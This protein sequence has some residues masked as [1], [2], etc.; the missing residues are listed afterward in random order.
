MSSLHVV[1]VALSFSLTLFTK[2]RIIFIIFRG[3]ISAISTLLAPLFRA[4]FALVK[5]NNRNE[6]KTKGAAM[7]ERGAGEATSTSTTAINAHS[8]TH[9]RT[10]QNC[11]QMSVLLRTREYAT[12]LA[13]KTLAKN[14]R[15]SVAH[16]IDATKTVRLRKVD[17]LRVCVSV[18]KQNHKTSRNKECVL[19]MRKVYVFF[20]SIVFF[21][22]S[23]P[24]IFASWLSL[25]VASSPFRPRSLPCCVSFAFL[26]D[27][28]S[29][30]FFSQHH[31]HRCSSTPY[32]SDFSYW[33]VVDGHFFHFSLSSFSSVVMSRVRSSTLWCT[34]AAH[35]II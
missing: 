9:R 20:S 29:F 11:V 16:I 28:L 27:F 25:L 30:H 13:E 31:R 8:H 12:K 2:D 5:H 19:Y 14:S 24:Y 23:S 34:A 32:F 15:A 21:P 26:H 7:G 35:N 17:S 10:E 1:V 6:A 3:Y 18:H 4:H 22:S 33:I